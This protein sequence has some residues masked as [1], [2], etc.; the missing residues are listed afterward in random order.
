MIHAQNFKYVVGLAPISLN[1]AACTPLTCDT[2]GFSYAAALVTFG[3]IGGAATV[4]RIE[5]SASDF[6]GAAITAYT[7]TG[8]TGNLRLP[9]TGDAG[10]TFLYGVPLG[11]ARLRY[12]QFAITTGATTLVTVNWI[13]S[14]AGQIPNTVAERGLTAQVFG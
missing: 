2:Q 8:S 1:S 10:K 3:V 6:S 11:G 9:Q 4:F 14:R 5:E 12:L 13:L 7:A